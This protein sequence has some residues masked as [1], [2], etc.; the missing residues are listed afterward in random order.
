MV[1]TS[2]GEIGEQMA[3]ESMQNHE[4]EHSFIA[5]LTTQTLTKAPENICINHTTINLNTGHMDGGGGDGGNGGGDGGDSDNGNGGDG[6]GASA[7]GG[8]QCTQSHMNDRARAFNL[9]RRL[10]K[11]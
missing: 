3:W 2:L 11:S 4:F 10:Q 8:T 1:H 9:C 5:S 7:Q 6:Q